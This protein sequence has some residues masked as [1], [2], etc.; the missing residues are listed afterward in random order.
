MVL[1]SLGGSMIRDARMGATGAPPSLDPRND[2]LT[3]ILRGSGAQVG[4]VSIFEGPAP[5]VS[6]TQAGGGAGGWDTQKRPPGGAPHKVSIPHAAEVLTP[7][8]PRFANSVVREVGTREVWG[9]WYEAN[10]I[11]EYRVGGRWRGRLHRLTVRAGTGGSPVSGVQVGGRLEPVEVVCERFVAERQLEV[12][13]LRWKM[14][15]NAGERNRL[16]RLK[17][18][19][20]T[21]PRR[22]RVKGGAGKWVWTWDGLGVGASVTAFGVTVRVE[23]YP[24]FMRNRRVAEGRLIAA[25]V[26]GCGALLDG[27]PAVWTRYHRRYPTVDKAALRANRER[28][29]VDLARDPYVEQLLELAA[30]T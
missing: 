19:G 29:G 16:R 25:L 7:V 4:P 14:R 11:P 23:A 6:A 17:R 18:E 2:V 30:L 20:W 13:R 1:Q 21:G 15:A 28:W 27:R 3:R 24:S 9:G 26:E 12:H 22:L 5:G 8:D 10:V